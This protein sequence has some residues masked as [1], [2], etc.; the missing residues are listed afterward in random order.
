MDGL[1][2]IKKPP[3]VTS[4]D[5]VKQIRNLLPGNKTGH[6]GTLDPLATGLL[7]L[8]V[9]ST[10]RLFPFFSKLGK[11]YEG[12]IRLG[13]STDT[14]DSLGKPVSPPS[15]DWPER[16]RLEQAMRDF[17]GSISQLPPP[18]SAKKHKGKPLYKLARTNQPTPRTPSQVTVHAFLCRGYSAP[19]IEFSVRCS[20]GTYIR[21]LAHD[22]GQ[23]LG[24][25]AH[26][27]RLVRTEVGRFLLEDAHS[28]EDISR[29]LKAGDVQAFLLPI[30]E[31]LPEFP[32]LILT[33]EGSSLASHGNQVAPQHIAR[34]YESEAPDATEGPPENQVFRLFSEGGRL[35]AFA[36][37]VP[38]QSGLHPFLVVDTGTA[39]K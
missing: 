19:D 25:G 18:Y 11:A 23:N 5:V 37:R 36:R 3:L 16:D 7:M 34:I 29:Y 20:S 13:F 33:E 9:G 26:L 2:L 10:T 30:E 14:Y 35:L 38:E 21:S 27:S 12:T 28:L 15:T 4:H 22:L 8:A 32:R 39:D 24:C 17:Q 31:L 6:F 1:I